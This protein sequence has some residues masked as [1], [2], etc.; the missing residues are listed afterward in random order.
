MSTKTTCWCLLIPPASS[1]ETCG[2]TACTIWRYRPLTAGVWGPPARIGPSAPQRE[3]RL[4]P[5]VPIPAPPPCPGRAWVRA[6]CLSL[7]PAVPSQ[8]EELHLEC[9]SDTSLLLHWQPPLS[10]NGVPTGYV[11]SYHPRT[12]VV[13]PE[14]QSSPAGRQRGVRG[15][16]QSWLPK[17]T[18]HL[19][20]QWMMGAWSSCP[21]TF[22]TLSCGCTT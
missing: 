18:P 12:C 8:P 7:Y 15:S 21:S 17:L 14:P 10:H 3:V 4:A 11:L 20:L 5:R 22:R 6:C 19:S 9:Q 2:P 13:A 16:G 1:W